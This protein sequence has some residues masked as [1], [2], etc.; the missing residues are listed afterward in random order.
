MNRQAAINRTVALVAACIA[1]LAAA[2]PASAASTTVVVSDANALQRALASAHPGDRI[3][4]RAGEYRIGQ[5]LAVPDG[6]S[7]EGSGVMQGAGLP[8]GFKPGTETAIV[9]LPRLTGDTVTLNNGAS[10]RALIVRQDINDHSGN[11]VSVGSRRPSD[12]VSA[13]I[14][15]C[16]IVNP[17]GPSGGPD[18]PTGGGV[19]VLTNNRSGAAAPAPDEAAEVTLAMRRSIVHSPGDAPAVFAINSARNGHIG[20]RLDL[21]VIGGRLDAAGG[22]SRGDLVT[23]AS[24]TI[25][26]AGN[27]YSPETASPG[28]TIVGGSSPPNP[29]IGTAGASSNVVRIGSTGDRIDGAPV[30][31]RAFGGQRLG[32]EFGPSSDNRVEL[33]IAGLAL[34]TVAADGPASDL[35]LAGAASMCACESPEFRAGDR[36]VVRVSLRDSTGSG[37]R[38]NVY[39]NVLGPTPPGNLG[40]GNRLAFAGTPAAFAA[41]NHD[42]DPAPD[43]SFFVG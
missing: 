15:E 26:S 29:A 19:A 1:G 30:G 32:T 37:P 40:A 17:N 21:N 27:L 43:A 42:I 25:D 18:G 11:A 22:V 38:D 36:N 33:V 41:S 23:G 5:T 31:I 24:L 28:W 20:L 13:T 9:A 39:A 6:V 16:E 8:T 35:V 4:V 12:S 3:L 7:V 34:R 14:V 2:M 10:L